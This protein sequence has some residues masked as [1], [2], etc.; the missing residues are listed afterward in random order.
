MNFFGG[1]FF[2]LSGTCIVSRAIFGNVS[3]VMGPIDRSLTG[4]VAYEIARSV[5]IRSI[6]GDAGGGGWVVW[7]VWGGVE[8]FI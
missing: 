1:P 4:K 7:G 2:H 6:F 3:Y 8:K 5:E